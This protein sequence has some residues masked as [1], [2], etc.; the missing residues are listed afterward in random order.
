VNLTLREKAVFESV[1]AQNP[2]LV[3]GLFTFEYPKSSLLVQH[4]A[5]YGTTYCSKLEMKIGNLGKIPREKAHLTYSHSPVDYSSE[6]LTKCKDY[7][8][9]TSSKL[10]KTI[11]K[12]VKLENSHL[13]G[14]TV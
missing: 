6:Y 3:F 12:V 13:K 4:S 5:F 10:K 2:H 8:T 1:L 7:F 14:L 9:E 11:Q